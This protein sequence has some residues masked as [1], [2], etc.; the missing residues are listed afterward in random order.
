M[1]LI[2][3]IGGT[4]IRAAHTALHLLAS[5]VY[6]SK[7]VKEVVHFIALDKDTNNGNAQDAGE[8]H[9]YFQGASAFVPQLASHT[10]K[11]KDI[12]LDDKEGGYLRSLAGQ[13]VGPGEKK[14]PEKLNRRFKETNDPL[15]LN[16]LFSTE[17]QEASLEDGFKQKPA[18]GALYF[19]TVRE[20][21]CVDALYPIFGSLQ[22]NEQLHVFLYGSLFG[23][24]GAALIY[25]VAKC[26]RDTS[27]LPRYN[28]PERVCIGGAMMLPYF[29]LPLLDKDEFERRKR[30]NKFR[31][32]TKDLIPIAQTAL[33]SYNAMDINELVRTKENEAEAG[34]G[35]VVFDALYPLGLYPQCNNISDSDEGVRNTDNLA[36]TTKNYQSGGG[37][38]KGRPTLV[39]L[40]AAQAMC[41]FFSM[42]DTHRPSKPTGDLLLPGEVATSNL[43]ITRFSNDCEL[44]SIGWGN[45][46]DGEVLRRQLLVMLKFSLY[47]TTYLA[48]RY[49]LA[50]KKEKTEY[51]A[52]LDRDYAKGRNGKNLEIAGKALESVFHYAVRFMEFLLTVATTNNG[53]VGNLACALLDTDNLKLAIDGVKAFYDEDKRPSQA[54]E[55]YSDLAKPFNRDNSGLCNPTENGPL[56]TN[57]E[58]QAQGYDGETIFNLVSKQKQAAAQLYPAI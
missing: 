22:T 10:F 18:I 6:K 19:E 56:E 25:Q 53:S 48:P 13:G 49:E 35:N 15:L 44:N 43:F 40:L 14:M 5:D 32:Q 16:W 24:T 58:A 23:G 4:G 17:D 47:I 39:D 33:A 9:A 21:F 54:P 36:A 3:G 52:Y 31:L 51:T 1:K 41:H 50:K 46:P 57:A 26:I 20:N 45:L 34:Q 55:Y 38:Q 8:T 11:W 42:A 28:F 30:D 29:M 37:Q 7:E 2:I 12:K 27:K